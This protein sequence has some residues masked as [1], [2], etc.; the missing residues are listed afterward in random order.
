MT[1]SAER[2]AQL[3]PHLDELLELEAPARDARLAELE[4]VDPGLAAD[5]R[6]LL[7]EDARE[8]GVLDRGVARIAPT[9]LEGLSAAAAVPA[10]PEGT[11]IGDYQLL[12]PLGRGGMGEVYLAR[13]STA[14][15]EQ[16]V[17]LKLLKRGMDSDELLRR[18]VQERRILAQLNHP[19]IAGFLD[20]GV[21]PDG[22][23]YFAMEFVDGVALTEFARSRALDL[24]ARVG[25]LATVCDAVAYAHT[26][27]VVHR[28]LKPSNILVDGNG[29][30][31]VLDFGIAKLL[32]DGAPS[33]TATAARAMSPAYA[34]PEQILGEP[35][36]TATD[37]YALGV[38]LFELLTGALPHD[39]SAASSAALALALVQ[40]TTT[41]PSQVL[42]QAP[43][44]LAAVLGISTAHAA[45]AARELSGDLDTIVLAALQ[46][47]PQ[48]RYG[49]AAALAE[50]LRRWLAGRPI[51]KRA[52]TPP[53]TEW[54]ASCAA[55][56]AP[57]CRLPWQRSRW[58]RRPACRCGRPTSRSSRRPAPMPRRVAPRPRRPR[59][60][61]RPSVFVGSRTSWCRCSCRRTRC[62]TPPAGP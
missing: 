46:R 45:R 25:L 53:A 51:A 27:L 56:A 15:V 7:A 48:R 19:H 54:R 20:G 30:P 4:E 47:E 50:D 23:P 31:R 44:R 40:E 8:A 14:G 6:R 38:V 49:T 33:D 3:S 62:G 22:R 32:G 29:Q 16:Q 24:R 55:I 34:A 1:W 2:W 18:F 21:E 61:S 37:V 12:R 39:R 17:A 52:P 13:R 5:L 43:D 26:Q 36:G 59:P 28:D 10:L 9:V 60:S 41:R 42:R 11:R 35:I 58:P 57:W